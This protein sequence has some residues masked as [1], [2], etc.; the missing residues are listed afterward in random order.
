MPPISRYFKGPLFAPH[1]KV[2]PST[3]TLASSPVAHGNIDE[4]DFL[5]KR[6]GRPTRK[7]LDMQRKDKEGK[8]E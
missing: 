8:D 7:D 4:E 6:T 2:K 5:S 1:R 3:E